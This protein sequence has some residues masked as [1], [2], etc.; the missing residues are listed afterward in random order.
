MCVGVYLVLFRVCRF[1]KDMEVIDDKLPY[2]IRPFLNNLF[3]I[4]TSVIVI[5]VDT[6]WF[7]AVIL[8][9]VVVYTVAQV[10]HCSPFRLQ[11]YPLPPPNL[12]SFLS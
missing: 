11:I 3:S 6:P 2:S 9:L 10:L 5:V 8:P 4:V 1:S 7:L 12:F